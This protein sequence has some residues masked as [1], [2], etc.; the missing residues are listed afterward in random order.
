MRKISSETQIHEN[1]GSTLHIIIVM[2]IK[3]KNL[4]HPK[5]VQQILP[6]HLKQGLFNAFENLVCPSVTATNRGPPYKVQVRNPTK[7]Y[8]PIHGVSKQAIIAPKLKPKISHVHHT[9]HQGYSHMHPIGF[10]TQHLLS[11]LS[12]IICDHLELEILE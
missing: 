9:S 2:K 5:L 3:Y 4:S 1:N 10:N 6:T 12:F 7:I 11:L 8:N